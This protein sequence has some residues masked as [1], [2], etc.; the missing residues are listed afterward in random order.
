MYS[1]LAEPVVFAMDRKMCLGI[2]RRAERN[3]R[4][5]ESKPDLLVE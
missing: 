1:I 2:K 4:H 3:F 5:A